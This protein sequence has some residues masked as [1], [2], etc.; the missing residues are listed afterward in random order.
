MSVYTTIRCKCIVAKEYRELMIEVLETPY[1]NIM[2][3]DRVINTIMQSAN[4][5]TNYFFGGSD[6][7]E[8]GDGH[9][10][11]QEPIDFKYDRV[12]GEWHFVTEVN[13][14]NAEEEMFFKLFVPRY[15][16]KI[17]FYES[18]IEFI[19][20]DYEEGK[21]YDVHRVVDDTYRIVTYNRDTYICEVEDCMFGLDNDTKITYNLS[22]EAYWEYVESKEHMSL[23]KYMDNENAK[24]VQYDEAEVKDM[25]RV[26]GEDYYMNAANR[27]KEIFG[28]AVVKEAWIALD[29]KEVFKF[30]RP[31]NATDMRKKISIMK[32]EEQIDLLAEVQRQIQYSGV[33]QYF[34][35]IA[36]Y[37]LGERGRIEVGSCPYNRK[38][39]KELRITFCNNK[40]IVIDPC[41]VRM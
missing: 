39:I 23:F 20:D 27:C 14:L 24:Y 34:K 40:S 15:I 3:E 5:F 9:F 10:T 38:M 8:D 36:N 41:G 1:S 30:K 28:E 16:E 13:H 35:N 32:Q 11:W 31:L 2:F 12:S 22:E 33:G 26:Q 19:Y 29:L 21:N 25:I 6:D 7:F 17:E 37:L 18:Y 4:R